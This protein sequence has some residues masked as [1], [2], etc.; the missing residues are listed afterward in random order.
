MSIHEKDD[1]F[2]RIN[3]EKGLNQTVTTK[4]GNKVDADFPSY[5]LTIFKMPTLQ[6]KN[7]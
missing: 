3:S 6:Q 2:Y 4:L 7:L 1:R 5:H